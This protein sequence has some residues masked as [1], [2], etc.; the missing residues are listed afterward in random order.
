MS[1]LEGQKAPVFNLEG[2]DGNK[3]SLAD[4]AGKNVVL[5]FYPKDDTPGCTKEACGFRDS[6]E[7]VTKANAVVLGISRDN[8]DSHNQFI[9]KF[10]LPFTLLS[11]PKVEVM[12]AY[13]AWGPR[14]NAQG[15]TVEGPIRSTALI[16]PD[17]TVKRHWIPVANAEAHPAEVLEFLKK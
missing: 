15:E 9:S 1:N 13:G 3:H 4:Y 6:M 5:Y 11:D 17:G 10:N 12:K 8:I 7:A 2:S 16:G 14:Q